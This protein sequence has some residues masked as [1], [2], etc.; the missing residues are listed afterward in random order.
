MII[1]KNYSLKNVLQFTGGHLVW[2][3]VWASAAV[4]T[5]HFGQ[6]RWLSIPWLPEI[7]L[8]EMLGETNLPK[9]ILAKD[10][11]LM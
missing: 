1:R 8:R 2:L 3:T 7:D 5:Y 4:C 10:G 11:I 6:L 9:P